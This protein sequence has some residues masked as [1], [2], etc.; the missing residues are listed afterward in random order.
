MCIYINTDY[1]LEHSFNKAKKMTTVIYNF[2][3]WEDI[4]DLWKVSSTELIHHKKECTEMSENKYCLRICFF[5]YALR[6]LIFVI[7]YFQRAQ[8][9]HHA[10]NTTLQSLKGYLHYKTILCHKVAPDV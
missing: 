3:I 7:T 4:V 2:T 9:R 10:W 5:L 6:K 1:W 8:N